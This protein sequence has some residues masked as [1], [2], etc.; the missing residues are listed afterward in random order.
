MNQNL[1]P[2]ILRTKREKETPSKWPR[3]LTPAVKEKLG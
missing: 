1:S 2:P 3:I